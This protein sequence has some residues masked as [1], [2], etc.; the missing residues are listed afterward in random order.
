MMYAILA[1]GLFLVPAILGIGAWLISSRDLKAFREDRAKILASMNAEKN[2]PHAEPKPPE[3]AHLE[4]Y[5]V[6]P[7]AFAAPSTKAAQVRVPPTKLGAHGTV[8]VS[9]K[10]AALLANISVVMAGKPFPIESLSNALEVAK[11]NYIQRNA[12]SML[13]T[14]GVPVVVPGKI[15]TQGGI[16]AKGR[17]KSFFIPYRGDEQTKAG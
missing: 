8:N 15:L 6:E 10:E 1:I 12:A 9:A 7:K 2:Q 4:H 3:E 11:E 13:E 17:K 5:L 16:K 14:V